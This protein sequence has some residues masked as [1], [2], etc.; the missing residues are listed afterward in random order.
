MGLLGARGSFA[1]FILAGIFHGPVYMDFST[2]YLSLSRRAFSS[3]TMRS[4]GF[5]FRHSS[6]MILATSGVWW[7]RRRRNIHLDVS[8][9]IRRQFYEEILDVSDGNLHIHQNIR[10]TYRT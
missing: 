2:S 3:Q 5:M 4:S 1:D 9:R 10:N 6:E 8:R 7:C